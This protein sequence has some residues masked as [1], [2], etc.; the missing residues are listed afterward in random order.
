MATITL[1]GLIDPHVHLRDPGQTEK[2]DFFT[3]TSAAVAGGFTTIVDMPNNSEPITTID[4]LEAKKKN[5]K[6]KIVCD[7]GL[8]FG[9]LG[10]NL[11]EFS[12]VNEG[13]GVMGLKIYLNQTTGNYLLDTKHLEAI[14][15]AWPENL[16]ILF[17]AEEE[18]F[19]GVLNLVRKHPR[20]VHLCHMSTAYEL[21]KV[22]Q[23][24]EEGLPISC[25]VTPHHLFLTEK[26]QKSL[27]VWGMMK[28]ALKP[29]HDVDF[30]W[31]N[32]QAVD[33]IESDHAPHTKKEKESDNPA[34]GVPG[35]ETTLPLLLTAVREGRLT[36]D[37]I[38]RLCH[39]GPRKLLGLPKSISTYIEVDTQENYTI[40]N[41][42]LFTKCKWTPFNGWKMTGKLQKVVIRDTPVFVQNEIK[43]NPGFGRVIA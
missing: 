19:D 15:K 25:G 28:P 39:D 11:D 13:R 27:G 21:K 7:L 24:K 32:L 37:E 6:E 12:K 8:Y 20:R 5:A 23:A 34:Y 4:R 3:G 41:K 17:H 36:I 33:L 31:K 26:D 2:E 29:Q 18:T 9:T 42:N 43:V 30:L 14:L 35:L 1:P 38:V 10:D 16:P 40:D 22:I